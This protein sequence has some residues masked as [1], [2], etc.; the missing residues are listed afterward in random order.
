MGHPRYH[1]EPA[2]RSWQVGLSWLFGVLVLATV[3]LLATQFTAIER[4]AEIARDAQPVWLLAAFVLQALTYAC[5]AGVWYVPLRRGGVRKSY[6]SIVP[7]GLAKLFTDQALPTGGIGGTLLVVSG[8]DRRGVPN[9]IGMAALLIGLV[10]Y[11]LAYLIAVL[12]ALAILYSSDSLDRPMIAAAMAFVLVAFG[13]P[14]IV[15]AIRHWSRRKDTDGPLASANKW[16]SRIPGF[17]ALMSA[18]SEAPS[19]LLRDPLSFAAAL[20]LQ[21][22]VFALDAA[23]LWVMLQALGAE[24]RP[25][26]AAAAFVMASLAATIGPM[27]LGLG[28][29]EAVCVTVLHVQ[30]LSVEIAL[31]ATLLLRGFTFWLP[32]IPGLVLARRELRRPQHAATSNA[33]TSPRE[34]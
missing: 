34:R 27:P 22:L 3:V 29:F 26:I 4:F 1:P 23:T 2:L 11:Y 30:G 25:T 5:A 17:S 31:T 28:T 16:L 6:W 10:S 15:F 24:A 33:R 18:M 14:A 8:L 13:I 21:I 7:L 9:G 12:T 20:V 19:K 32:M